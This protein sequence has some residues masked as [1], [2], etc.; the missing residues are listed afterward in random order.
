M[1]GGPLLTRL[2]HNPYA[3]A[4]RKIAKLSTPYRPKNP[5]DMF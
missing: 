5:N 4:A 3:I 1:P 2:P